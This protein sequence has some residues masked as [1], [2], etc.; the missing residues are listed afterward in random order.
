MH[1]VE[2]LKT[3]W[4]FCLAHIPETSVDWVVFYPA[5]QQAEIAQAKQSH[6][7]GRRQDL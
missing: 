5:K 4:Y 1:D 2:V 3:I 7:C 6:H